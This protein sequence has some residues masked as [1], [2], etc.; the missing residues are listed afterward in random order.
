MRFIFLVRATEE[1]EA[2][3]TP[4]QEFIDA[5][6]EYGEQL[7]KAGVA[8][9]AELLRPSSQGLRVAYEDGNVSMIDGPFVDSKELVAAYW[10]IE[11]GSKAEAAEWAKQVPFKNGLL[12]VRQV[13]SADDYS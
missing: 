4:S 7:Y 9:S 11:V 1:S 8:V 2:G 10:Q 6:N 5:V 3:A 13:Y 12:E